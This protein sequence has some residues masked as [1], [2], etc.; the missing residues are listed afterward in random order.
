MIRLKG[1]KTEVSGFLDHEPLVAVHRNALPAYLGNA[2]LAADARHDFLEADVRRARK[3]DVRD[4]LD[5][6]HGCHVVAIER[7]KW[8]TFMK[9]HVPVMTPASEITSSGASKACLNSGPVSAH[10]WPPPL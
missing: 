10:I 6:I 8:S 7:L 4:D 1:R 9:G 5:T 3:R 2:G